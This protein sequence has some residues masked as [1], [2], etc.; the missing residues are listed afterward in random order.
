MQCNIYSSANQ[1]D[2]VELL[3]TTFQALTEGTQGSLR[4][5]DIT[6][7]ESTGGRNVQSPHPLRP[8]AGLKTPNPK[9]HGNLVLLGPGQGRFSCWGVY[10][11]VYVEDC[12]SCVLGEEMRNANPIEA[13]AQTSNPRFHQRSPMLRSEPSAINAKPKP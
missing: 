9:L 12:M 11:Q 10:E 8:Q 7:I 13:N 3:R 4:P 5:N 6:W 2:R 1:H